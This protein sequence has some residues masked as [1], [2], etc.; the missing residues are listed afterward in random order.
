MEML[1]L[2]DEV[3]EEREKEENE[4]VSGETTAV[5]GQKQQLLPS[6][7]TANTEKA[8]ELILECLDVCR[9]YRQQLAEVVPPNPPPA[10]PL[11]MQANKCSSVEQFLLETFKR[12]RARYRNFRP[13]QRK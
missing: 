4:L 11:L 9:D 7:K 1:V 13:L 10:L 2:E 12:V 8:A 6:R 5:P 3:E